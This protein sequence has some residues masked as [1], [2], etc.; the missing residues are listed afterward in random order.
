[1]FVVGVFARLPAFETVPE[2]LKNA[3]SN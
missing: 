3:D 1:L 2:Q